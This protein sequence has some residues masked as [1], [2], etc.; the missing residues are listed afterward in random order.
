[1]NVIVVGGGIVGASTAYHLALE[2]AHVTLVDRHDEGQATAA[3]AGIVCPWI[4]ERKDNQP[5]YEMARGGAHYYGTLVELLQ[6]DGENDWGFKRVGAL[7]VSEDTAELDKIEKQAHDARQTSPEV[8]EI[9]RMTNVGARDLFP[10]LGAHLDAVHLSGAARV[11]GQQLR[12]A[13][14]RGAEKQGAEIIRGEARL[15]KDGDRVSGVYINETVYEADHVF[16]AVGAWTADIL[17]PIGISLPI[18]PQRGQ[19]IHL[20]L[21]EA[22]TS[23]WPVVLP[24]TSY[25]MLAFND[26]RVVVGASREDGVGFDY[27]PTAAGIQEV[28][29][30]A[31]SVAPGLAESKVHET[32]IGFR[33]VGPDD[34]PLMGSIKGVEGLS[35]A[36]GLGPSGLTMGPY[37]GK[38]MSDAIL[39][40]DGEMDLSPYDPLRFER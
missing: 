13:L 7:A 40:K 22:D 4:S 20:Q 32:R 6:A 37:V 21:A 5:W 28:L 1:M 27:R 23:D 16:V 19:I 9:T 14:L 11:D 38:C 33:P 17:T 34:V 8:G 2:G 3:G 29:E 10:P 26:S 12:D 25:Y 30:S 39:G 24:R 31:L 36:N 35:V 15:K 18:E